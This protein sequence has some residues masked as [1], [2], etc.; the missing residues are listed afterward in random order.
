M[1]KKGIVRFVAV[2]LACLVLGSAFGPTQTLQAASLLPAPTLSSPPNGQT[3]TSTT[4]TFSWSSVSEANYYWLTVATNPSYLP[5]DPYAT[6]APGC[7]IGSNGVGMAATSYTPSTPLSPGTTYY[8][9]VQAYHGSDA[10]HPDR[11]GQYSAQWSF[12]TATA[13]TPTPTLLPAPTLSSPPNG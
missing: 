4:P 8:W 13:P 10:Y 3:G 12:T 1:R 6:S 7:V 11:Q 9:K 2:L 5:T